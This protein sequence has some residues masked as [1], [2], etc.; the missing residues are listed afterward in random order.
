[1][2]VFEPGRVP[3]DHQAAEQAAEST[4]Q[5]TYEAADSGVTNSKHGGRN[6]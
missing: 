2:R 3:R 6:G 4:F 1:M 5:A